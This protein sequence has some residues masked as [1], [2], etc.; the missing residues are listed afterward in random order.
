MKV[1]C[2]GN[3]CNNPYRTTLKRDFQ[4]QRHILIVVWE[5]NVYRVIRDRHSSLVINLFFTCKS[6]HDQLLTAQ[7]G[8]TAPDEHLLCSQKWQ[9]KAFFFPQGTR[10]FFL[11][12]LSLCLCRVLKI[13]REAA[14][15]P[16]P[17]SPESHN[18]FNML[19]YCIP[20]LFYKWTAILK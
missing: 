1:E 13:L 7:Y 9:T 3:L 16:Y 4:L 2:T 20:F 15:A 17:I 12:V 14:T 5:L 11:F 8:L 6:L 19:M 10:I 18:V